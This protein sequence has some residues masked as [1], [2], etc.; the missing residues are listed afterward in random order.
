MFVTRK[1]ENIIRQELKN[2]PIIS[3]IGA[4]QVGKT[5]LSQKLFPEK[6]YVNLEDTVKRSQAKEDI[7]SFMEFYK[8]GAVF[9]E[10]QN[11]PELFSH[12]QV[13]VDN[14]TA[15]GRFI[16]T[17]SQNLLISE[18]ISQSL[19]GRVGVIDMYPFSYSELKNAKLNRKTRES[20]ILYGSYPPVYDRK[21]NPVS[22]YKN[23]IRTYIQKD[24]NQI[25]K[26][27]N[28]G[29]FI[30]FIKLCALNAGQIFN[31]A[32]LASCCDVDIKTINSW[33]SILEQTYIIFLLQP[34]YRN[35]S[36]RLVKSPKLYFYDTG[37]ICSLLGIKTEKQLQDDRGLYG[38][39]FE[40][41]SISELIK[42]SAIKT[43]ESSFY[44]WRDS[45][46][47]EID[48]IIDSGFKM[49]PVEIKLS[50]TPRTDFAGNIVKWKELCGV[51]VEEG[52]VIYGGTEKW[53]IKGVEYLPWSSVD[54]VFL[55]FRNR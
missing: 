2:H 14:E 31:I 3:I 32:R 38:F 52:V 10:I 1:I 40:N 20:A 15:P 45:N 22:W 54:E 39:L 8:N 9:D 53:S 50:A 16:I 23:Y 49:L 24:I 41:W 21:L 12:L 6:P 7:Y 51:K 27:R 36:K 11:V 47:H 42:N 33:L 35:F 26:I 25:L 48:L 29:K 30:R 34:Y 5:L 18:K 37:I 43:E 4:R 44:Y 28:S 13:A 17:G 46:G 55:N 19:A